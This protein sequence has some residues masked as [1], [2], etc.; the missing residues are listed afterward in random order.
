[1][2]A[3]WDDGGENYPAL[4]VWRSTGEREY[5]LVRGTRITATV[6]S[7]TEI[8]E[9][10]VSGYNPPFTFQEGDI[11][12]IFLPA[13][14]PRLGVYFSEENGPPNYYVDTDVDTPIQTTFQINGRNVDVQHEIPLVA[15]EISTFC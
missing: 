15:V 5:M 3:Q 14:S 10:D 4:Q 8:Y 2:A 12:G 11:L 1:M 13:H 6:E 7:S 9:Y